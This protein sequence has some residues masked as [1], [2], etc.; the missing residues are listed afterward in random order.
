MEI[1][2]LERE[3]AVINGTWELSMADS[4]AASNPSEQS[5]CTQQPHSPEADDA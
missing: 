3:Q 2:A 4:C 1:Q 5:E